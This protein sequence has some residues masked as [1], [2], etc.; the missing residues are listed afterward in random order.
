MAVLRLYRFL[1]FCAVPFLRLSLRRRALAGRE[2]KARLRERMGHAS[3]K[4]PRGPLAWFHAAS[5]GEVNSILALIEDILRTRPAQNIVLTTGTVTSAIIVARFQTAHPDLRARLKHQ[6]APLDVMRWNCRFLDHWQPDA[7]F[8]VESELWPNMIAAAAARKLPLVMVNGRLS[9][10]SFRRW[11]KLR[12]TAL[13]LLGRFALLTAQ[14]NV[15]A[16]RLEALGLRGIARPGNLKL[17]APPPTVDEA[18]LNKVTRAMGDRPVWLAASTHPG[19]EEILAA[20]HR[21]LRESHEQLVTVI[22]PRH[23]D[24]GDA[25]AAMLRQKNLR[26]A[27]RSQA[28]P[29][30]AETDIYLMDTLGE[31]GLA[32]RLADIVFIGGTLVPH[33]GQN[34]FEAAQLACALLHGPHVE[35]FEPLFD[36]LTG[37]QAA[38]EISDAATLATQVSALLTAPAALEKMAQAAKSYSREMGGARAHMLDL[39]SPY[40]ADTDAQPAPARAR[41]AH[42]G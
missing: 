17:D 32:Y 11:Q 22:V 30:T 20:A 24:R 14:D 15:T 3:L 26:V 6:Y 12:K 4:R 40:L 29:V 39:L 5:V 42:D 34:P 41:E 16:Q 1:T 38:A 35:N 21:L 27:Q 37:R 31:M 13:A 9:P 2:D 23:P 36:D 7:G 10:R 33:G 18:A 28:K 25:I 8:W 19:E